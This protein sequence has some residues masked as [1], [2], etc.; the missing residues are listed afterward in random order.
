MGQATRTIIVCEGFLS[1][2]WGS[3]S[4]TL[5]IKVMGWVIKQ[6]LTGFGIKIIEAH[7]VFPDELL[8][9][10]CC[11]LSV[12]SYTLIVLPGVEEAAQTNQA[13]VSVGRYSNHIQPLNLFQ[14]ALFI[15]GSCL[16][17]RA[18]SVYVISVSTSIHFYLYICKL[19]ITLFLFTNRS[20][21]AGLICV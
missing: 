16:S 4:D 3:N 18:D 19:I 6:Q 14:C 13:L 10:D 8:Q 1:D 11:N 17:V 12:Y 2:T 15:Y 5:L 20:I 9:L 7:S 21:N